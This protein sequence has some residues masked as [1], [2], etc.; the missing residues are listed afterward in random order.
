MKNVRASIQGWI[1]AHLDRIEEFHRN[2]LNFAL[3]ALELLNPE[4]E[5]FDLTEEGV[6]FGKPLGF[7]AEP[8]LLLP[9]PPLLLAEPP[10]LF[11]LIIGGGG[12]REAKER[13][14]ESGLGRL[15]RLGRGRGKWVLG[16]EEEE[17]EVVWGRDWG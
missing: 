13:S 6:P 11:S 10:G 16:E 17:G 15:W 3:S 12:E 1:V 2:A 9:Q 14:G 5:G 4:L 8:P 7:L